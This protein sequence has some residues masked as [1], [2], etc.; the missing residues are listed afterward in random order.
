MT[1][2]SRFFFILLRHLFVDDLFFLSSCPLPDVVSPARPGEGSSAAVRA[3]VRV[4]EQRA[5][6]CYW[7]FPPRVQRSLADE[8]E[9]DE[10]EAM[11][12]VRRRR[13]SVFDN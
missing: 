1:S 9:R 8:K 10:R 13:R 5:A 6:G 3:S 12:S 11:G 2:G 7:R 4:S